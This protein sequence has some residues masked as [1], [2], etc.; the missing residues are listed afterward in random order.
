M[1]DDTFPRVTR[2]GTAANTIA[3]LPGHDR[4]AKIQARLSLYR[5]G[6]QLWVTWHGWFS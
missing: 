2:P 3:I 4:G 1:P 5:F 6:G